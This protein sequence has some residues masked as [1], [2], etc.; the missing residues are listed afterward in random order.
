MADDQIS[1]WLVSA[2]WSANK[3]S[4]FTSISSTALLNKKVVTSGVFLTPS[5]EAVG[6]P[7]SF[8]LHDDH[9]RM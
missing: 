4:V 8:C 3:S 6:P 2:L 7:L 5:N 9:T 1:L